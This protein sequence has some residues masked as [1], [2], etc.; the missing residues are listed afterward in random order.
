MARAATPLRASRRP[1]SRRR[2]R[3]TVY[4]LSLGASSRGSRKTVLY[5]CLS[6]GTLGRIQRPRRRGLA[7]TLENGEATPFELRLGDLD[8]RDKPGGSNLVEIPGCINGGGSPPRR[9]S[10]SK[11]NLPEDRNENFYWMAHRDFEATLPRSAN[12]FP[13]S[14]TRAQEEWTERTRRRRVLGVA[15]RHPAYRHRGTTGR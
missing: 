11:A 14:T 3:R 5:D 2:A 1:A 7:S 10:G 15:H 4:C 6:Y 12:H 8:G 9:G 13:A